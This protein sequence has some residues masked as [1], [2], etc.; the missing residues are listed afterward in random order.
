[1]LK[2]VNDVPVK[3]NSPSNCPTFPFTCCTGSL[4]YSHTI[5]ACFPGHTM[6][7]IAFPLERSAGYLSRSHIIL[8]RFPAHILDR[9]AFPLTRYEYTG[10]ISRSHTV[11]AWFP[12][13]TLYWLDF[14]THMLDRLAFALT[15]CTGSLSRS[16]AVQA[17]WASTQRSCFSYI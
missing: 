1:M 9:L 14:P 10:L 5:P 8:I 17:C 15:W 4:F 12:S 2:S 11:L 6:Y 16:N 13:H 3:L 7:R